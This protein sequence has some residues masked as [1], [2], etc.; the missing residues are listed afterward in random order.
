MD[1]GTNFE[2]ARGF[3]RQNWKSK[4]FQPGEDPTKYDSSSDESVAAEEKNDKMFDEFGDPLSPYHRSHKSQTSRKEFGL[5]K[6]MNEDSCE[7]ID[8]TIDID[9]I[10]HMLSTK[11]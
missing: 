11:G 3:V 10:S 8:T 2:K 9:N 4:H 1:V 6:M 5:K 7:L